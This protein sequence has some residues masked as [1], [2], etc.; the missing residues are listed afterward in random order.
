[1]LPVNI[2]EPIINASQISADR[3]LKV[4]GY[5]KTLE[6]TIL[7]RDNTHPEIYYVSTTG[8]SS[9]MVYAQKNAATYAIGS[10]VLV[11]VPEGNFDN[12]KTIIGEVV[13]K[14]AQFRIKDPEDDFLLLQTDDWQIDY[15]DNLIIEDQIYP[16]CSG[17]TGG[18]ET[19]TA[20]KRTNVVLV[21]F[22]IERNLSYITKNFY[23]ILDSNKKFI[24]F[25]ITYKN[26]TNSSETY[27]KLYYWPLSYYF[28]NIDMPNNEQDPSNGIKKEFSILYS[29]PDGCYISNVSIKQSS[30][31]VYIKNIDTGKSK[32]TYI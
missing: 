14:N 15:K 32:I 22:T 11:N 9:L 28:G 20:I 4:A 8:F 30:L 29:V 19:I 6:C 12:E 17:P 25:E 26:L 2:L 16:P 7:S 23:Q 27:S 5:D 18:E 21:K 3:F 10:T 31:E 13:D 24:I 1:M